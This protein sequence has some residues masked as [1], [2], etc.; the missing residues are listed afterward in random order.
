MENKVHPERVM[1]TM[2]LIRD[3]KLKSDVSKT[4]SLKQNGLTE[5]QMFTLMSICQN[6]GFCACGKCTTSELSKELN[7]FLPSASRIIDSLVI[8][9][10]VSRTVHEKDRRKINLAATEG[11]KA[12][13]KEFRSEILEIM[14]ELL[15]KMG[16]EEHDN[17]INGLTAFNRVME[18]SG[19]IKL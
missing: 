11:G 10:L 13:F 1:E 17:L 15:G 12:V 18:E 14:S 16:Q 9:K 3:L 2:K 6:S 4:K 5:L 7:I 8:K 19:N